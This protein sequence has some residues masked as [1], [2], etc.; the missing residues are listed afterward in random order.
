MIVKRSLVLVALLAATAAAQPLVA[1]P[2]SKT[3][4]R[5]IKL[6]DKA[7]Y[8]SA[9]IELQKVLDGETGDDAANQQRADFFMGKTLVKMHFEF[10]GLAYFA[11]IVQEGL[12]H[13][14]YTATHK[15]LVSIFDLPGG[16]SQ[17][18]LLRSMA[19]A[20]LVDPSLDG[21]VRSGLRYFA[22]VDAMHARDVQAAT[23]WFAAIPRDSAWSP[24]AHLMLASL[25]GSDVAPALAEAARDPALARDI[26]FQLATRSDDARATK[27]LEGM[28][29]T[30]P[31][32][33]L[34]RS[35]RAVVARRRWPTT[36]GADVANALAIGTACAKGETAD[37]REAMAI[38]AAEL[39]TVATKLENYDDNLEAY[40]YITKVRR[41]ALDHPARGALHVLLSDRVTRERTD[42]VAELQGELARTESS[43]RAW[44]TTQIAAEVQQEL[45]VQLAVAM[46]DLGKH[47]RDRLGGSSEDIA[48]LADVLARRDRADDPLPL[49]PRA[50]R[51]LVVSVELCRAALG[52]AGRLT[53]VAVATTPVTS[54]VG[55]PP[56]QGKGCGG[57]ATSSPASAVVL[58]VVVV[59]LARPR[60][61]RRAR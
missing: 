46:A 42:F 26:V 24:R 9:S 10:A 51:G 20:V 33:A 27:L 32:A 22:G 12:A 49:G 5:A 8:F 45:L 29:A 35:R 55:G 58:L 40:E 50:E 61:A 59:G 6:Y 25:P 38:A 43:D 1:G 16:E 13:T 11:K 2:P 41:L 34:E 19:P 18:G 21:E 60:R 3:L 53:Q 17:V 31:H 48:Q 44:Q 7:D 52:G 47:Y 36:I 39:R 37:G 57:C 14:Y 56:A 15:W 4:E 54:P 23:A 28:V 30:S